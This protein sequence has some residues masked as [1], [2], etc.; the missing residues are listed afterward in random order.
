MFSHLYMIG[1]R[2]QYIERTWLAGCEVSRHGWFLRAFYM[3]GSAFFL[4]RFEKQ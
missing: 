3:Q 1:P 2:L 4:I